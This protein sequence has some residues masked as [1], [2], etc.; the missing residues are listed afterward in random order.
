MEPSEPGGISRINWGIGRKIAVL[1][2]LANRV[3]KIDTVLMKKLKV[4]GIELNALWTF[5][6]RNFLR[7]RAVLW[8]RRETRT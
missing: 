2:L 4:S 5:F 6:T 1:R 8:R 3:K 7:Q